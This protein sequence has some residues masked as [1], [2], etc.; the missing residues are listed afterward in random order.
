MTSEAARNALTRAIRRILL[1]HWDPHGLAGTPGAGD[2]YGEEVREILALLSD[3]AIT[4]GRIAHYLEWVERNAL[5]LQPRPGAA[6]AAA[7]RLVALPHPDADVA[8]D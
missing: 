8:E 7:A 3:P 2:A 1:E 5:H 4:A 6:K